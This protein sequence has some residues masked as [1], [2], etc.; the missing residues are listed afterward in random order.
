MQKLETVYEIDKAGLVSG[1]HLLAGAP[2]TFRRSNGTT[3]TGNLALQEKLLIQAEQELSVAFFEFNDKA[4]I[5]RYHN[6]VEQ[7]LTTPGLKANLRMA[8]STL[9]SVSPP[10]IT[11]NK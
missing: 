6:N 4:Y 2:V 8:I 5:N 11:A 10:E 7:A 3:F 1:F 9:N